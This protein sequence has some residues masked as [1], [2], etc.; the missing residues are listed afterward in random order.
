MKIFKL[1]SLLFT[2]AILSS[3]VANATTVSCDPSLGSYYSD[4]NTSNLTFRGKISDACAGVF[5]GND[6]GKKGNGIANL[7]DVFGGSWELLLNSD[8][9]LSSSLANYDVNF[10]LSEFPT[11]QTAGS[12]SLSWNGDDLPIQMDIAAVVKTSNNW[13]TYLFENELFEVSPSFG[14]GEWQSTVI[15]NNDVAQALSHFSLYVR[16][17][18]EPLIPPNE[19]PAPATLILFAAGLLGFVARKSKKSSSI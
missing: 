1:S 6:M 17:I 14:T 12:W 11:E 16:D 8:S 5:E 4:F 19:I 7:N 3:N 15:N 10:S 13:S 2:A 9:L 18:S